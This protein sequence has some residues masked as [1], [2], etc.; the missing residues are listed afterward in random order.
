V[1]E[2][3]KLAYQDYTTSLS[4]MA[5]REEA[6]ELKD[7]KCE[8]CGAEARQVHHKKYPESFYEDC[9]DN[10]EGV[11]VYAKGKKYKTRLF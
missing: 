8:G 11:T 9:I 4:W 5:L 6:K 1:S 7:Y 3:K 10:L 2:L